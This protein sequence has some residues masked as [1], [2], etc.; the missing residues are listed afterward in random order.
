MALDRF[1]RLHPVRREVGAVAELLQQSQCELLVHHVVLGEQ[2]AQRVARGHAGI[3]ARLARRRRSVGDL[4]Q[5]QTH[6]RVEK[7]RLAHDLMPPIATMPITSICR[8]NRKYY[9]H[10]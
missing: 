2:N 8:W 4:V 10:E 1:D 9:T 5:Q 7:L 6:Q 3:H